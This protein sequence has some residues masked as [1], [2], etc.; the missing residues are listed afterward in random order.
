MLPVMSAF[1][2]LARRS[3]VH[4]I[5][6]RCLIFHDWF[7]FGNVG[8]IF[9]ALLGFLGTLWGHFWYFLAFLDGFPRIALT[10]LTTRSPDHLMVI[11]NVSSDK[12]LI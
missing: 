5:V 3:Y 1:V 6:F 2:P 11:L 7:N 12:S 9:R 8:Y 4:K 10:S